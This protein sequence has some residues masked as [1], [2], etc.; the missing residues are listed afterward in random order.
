MAQD[1]ARP[2]SPASATPAYMRAST[3][4]WRRFGRR[5]GSAATAH[6]WLKGSATKQP[7]A[8][9]PSFMSINALISDA[10]KGHGKLTNL[11]ER[12][13]KGQ[14]VVAIKDSKTEHLLPSRDGQAGTPSLP[15]AALD[16]LHR[17][18]T[19]RCRS[20]RRKA[21][22]TSVRSRLRARRA[23]RDGP[24]HRRRCR[25]RGTRLDVGQHPDDLVAKK[26]LLFEKSCR[27]PV[28]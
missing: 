12:T 7:F 18:E 24:R 11:G 5:R 27:E 9:S 19:N 3:D 20:P 6:K 17:L 25:R 1:T 23:R 16:Q 10:F 15:A 4:F 26:R 8:A 2:T 28:E 13:Y 22:S 14:K 21:L